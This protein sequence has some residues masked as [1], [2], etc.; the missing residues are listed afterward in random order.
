[1]K[2]FAAALLSII[3]QSKRTDRSQAFC[4]TSGDGFELDLE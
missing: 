2:Y 4:T 1:M 3:A